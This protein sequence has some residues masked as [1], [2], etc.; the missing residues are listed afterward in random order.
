[1]NKIIKNIIKKGIT[2]IRWR[3]LSNGVYCFNY[4]RIG[5]SKDTQYDSDI[6]SCT[7]EVFLS[8]LLF[9]KEYFDI[10]SID[11]M[12]KIL[13]TEIAIKEKLALITFDDGYIDNYNVAYKI[14]KQQSIP[15]VFYVPTSY[16]GSSSIPW[17]DE[18]AWMIRN[19]RSKTV[20]M[21]QWDRDIL[22]NRENIEQSIR[23]V[24]L[25]VKKMVGMEMG[26]ILAQLR[27]QLTCQAENSQHKLFMNWDNLK[28]MQD[29]GM[30][31]G[32]HTHS[33]EILSHINKHLQYEEVAKSKAI[34]ER[35]LDRSVSTFAYPV[36]RKG[37]YT[38]ETIDVLKECGYKLAFTQSLGVNANP[39]ENRFELRRFPVD[40]NLDA[41]KIPQLI[42]LN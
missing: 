7:S 19:T 9:Y 18:I 4:H 2:S 31:I 23:T 38:E 32:S 30:G 6:Y 37:T 11:E 13:E 24:L 36:G 28:E 27:E 17:W 14:L 3:G 41:D 5:E 34:L 12:E 21:T 16:V 15:A 35:E 39:K 26:D 8:H 42:C 10:I 33:H 22:I 20:S 25:A 1:M 29:N 40:G